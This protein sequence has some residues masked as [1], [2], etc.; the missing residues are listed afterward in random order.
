MPARVKHRTKLAHLGFL[1]AGL[2]AL[3][4]ACIPSY[5]PCECSREELDRSTPCAD[6]VP[7]PVEGAECGYPAGPYG[8][9]EG[10]VLANLELFDCMGEAVQIAQYIPQEGLPSAD[11]KAVVLG[12]GAAWCQPCAE[13][14]NEWAADLVDVW[15]PRGV[16][17]LQAL[18]EGA[19]G[20]ATAEIC[21]GWSSANAMDKFPIL[22]TPEQASL[23][24]TIS[25]G[26]GMPI[27]YTLILDVN[28]TIELKHTGGILDAAQ[29]EGQL[30]L[31]TEDPNGN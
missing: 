18:D 16:Q 3:T 1:G 22:F 10:D 24:A 8:Y 4:S 29:L 27:P 19:S 25:G 13:E 11:N 31:L 17:F 23:Q 28:A 14:A 20:P 30:E 5:P 6:G 21:A 15:E 9:D 26:T 7:L 12:I 2:V